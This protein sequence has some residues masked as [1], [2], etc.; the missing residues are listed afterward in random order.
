[1]PT[2]GNWNRERRAQRARSDDI[3]LLQREQSRESVIATLL[4]ISAHGIG[5]GAEGLRSGEVFTVSL[6]LGPAKRVLKCSAI[7]RHANGKHHGLEF[8]DLS[9]EQMRIL[10]EACGN[11]C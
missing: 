1:M 6:A 4:D 8:L 10:A 3:V 9:D 2:S 11:H 7:V 5:V